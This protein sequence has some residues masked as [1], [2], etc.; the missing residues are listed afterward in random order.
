MESDEWLTIKEAA[1]YLKLSVSTIRKKIKLKQ[2]PCY[3]Q[4]HT[5]RIKRSD[6]DN[7]FKPNK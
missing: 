7:F 4:E 2:L 5:I 1:A 6:L 3:R